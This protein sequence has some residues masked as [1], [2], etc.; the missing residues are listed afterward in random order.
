MT[1]AGDNTSER[2]SIPKASGNST[3]TARSAMNSAAA[4]YVAGIS[5]VIVGRPLDSAK[6]WLQ[7]N[8]VGQNK[9]LVDDWQLRAAVVVP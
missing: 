9:H 3:W 2:I 5:G 8:S 7:T 1:K 6:F 4:G